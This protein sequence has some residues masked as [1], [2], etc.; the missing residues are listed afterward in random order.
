[1]LGGNVSLGCFSEC[2]TRELWA[3]SLAMKLMKGLLLL[4]EWRDIWG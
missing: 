1:M 2:G 3:D 4:L